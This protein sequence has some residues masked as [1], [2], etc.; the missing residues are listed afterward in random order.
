M[1]ARDWNH[2]TDGWK[3]SSIQRMVTISIRLGWQSIVLQDSEQRRLAFTTY[4]HCV[5]A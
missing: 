2:A 4:C 5:V 1:L 3:F